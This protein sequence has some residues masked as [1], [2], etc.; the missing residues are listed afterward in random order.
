M[1]NAKQI[2]HCFI[3]NAHQNIMEIPKILFSQ[4]T[5]VHDS[6]L[7][8]CMHEFTMA[9]FGISCNYYTWVDC[10]DLTGIIYSPTL[11]CGSFFSIKNLCTSLPQCSYVY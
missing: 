11:L 6:G 1:C 10:G 5:M 4:S 3:Q 7:E 9:P 2:L 8:K